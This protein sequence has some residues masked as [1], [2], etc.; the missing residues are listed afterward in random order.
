MIDWLAAGFLLAGSFFFF[1]G[2]MG[3]LRFPDVFSRLHALTKVDNLGLGLTVSGLALLSGS[4][5]A[6]AKLILIW[7]L[8][9]VASASAGYLMANSALHQGLKPWRRDVPQAAHD[10]ESR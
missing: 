3:L 9:L 10:E 6:A 8:A 1:A 7:L 2:T 4:W 5:L